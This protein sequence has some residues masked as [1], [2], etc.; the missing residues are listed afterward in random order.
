MTANNNTNTTVDDIIDEML[1]KEAEANNPA[2]VVEASKTDT[3][4]A[5]S[6]S[7]TIPEV[8]AEKSKSK[9]KK[10]KE[11]PKRPRGRPANV[12]DKAFME[13]HAKAK[14][15]DDVVKAFK[16]LREMEPK[17]AKLYV[18]M[19]SASLRKNGHN[20]K[21]FPRGKRKSAPVVVT[22]PVVA[23]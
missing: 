23:E 8:K 15:V 13:V 19:R 12:T 6:K 1:R 14:N 7:E 9:P 5:E 11:G 4:A 17:K 21:L 18:S 2:V 10:D 3:S 16:I 22:P 20:L